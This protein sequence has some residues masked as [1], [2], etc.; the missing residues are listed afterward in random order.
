[1]DSSLDK[2]DGE[3]R[4]GDRVEWV[5]PSRAPYGPDHGEGGWIVDINPMDDCIQ[6]DS[7]TDTGNYFHP[8]DAEQIRFVRRE[9]DPEKRFL[10]GD[11]HSSE[12]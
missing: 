10:I 6:W 3:F 12:S 2:W 1:M 4:V 8:P 5:G 11:P 7:T 9:P